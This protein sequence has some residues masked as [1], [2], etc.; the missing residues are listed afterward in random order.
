[1]VALLVMFFSILSS[2]EKLKEILLI[3]STYTLKRRV[4]LLTKPIKVVNP[5][6]LG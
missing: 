1:M 4:E 5:G 6:K 3:S 2:H